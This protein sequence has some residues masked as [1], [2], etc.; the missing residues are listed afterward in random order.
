MYI[1]GTMAIFAVVCFLIWFFSSRDAGSSPAESIDGIKYYYGIYDFKEYVI[2]LTDT[3][4]VIINVETNK[5]IEFSR[6]ISENNSFTI[7]FPNGKTVDCEI[8]EDRDVLSLDGFDF[9]RV[10]FEDLKYIS[11]TD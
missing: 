7:S 11:K 10:Q 2:L 3:K 5:T 1:F 9:D 4:I 6:I 8:V